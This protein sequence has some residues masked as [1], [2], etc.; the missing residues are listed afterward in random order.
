MKENPIKFYI[1]LI[2]KVNGKNIKDII[3]KKKNK[4]LNIMIK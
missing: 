3:M 2:M 4:I 1:H